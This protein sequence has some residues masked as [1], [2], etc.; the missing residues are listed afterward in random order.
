MVGPDERLGE[1]AAEPEI[2]GAS[3]EAAAQIARPLLVE[4]GRPD[5]VLYRVVS[6]RIA[7]LPVESRPGIVP[8]LLTDPSKSGVVVE[9][10]RLQGGELPEDA[11]ENDPEK[12]VALWSSKAAEL[13]PL[14]VPEG[15]DEQVMTLADEL[16]M[17]GGGPVVYAREEVGEMKPL[18]DTLLQVVG[19][20]NNANR[21]RLQSALAYAEAHGLEQP[22]V[23]TVDPSRI[24][25]EKERDVV[26]EFA[27]EATNELELFVDSAIDQGFEPVAEDNR[28]GVRF[29]PDG[30]SYLT[31]S[32]PDGAQMVV[33]APARHLKADG[34][35]QTGV[36]NAYHALLEHP[37]VVSED[38]QLPGS[39]VIHV[40][41]SH[42]GPMGA[43][44][45]LNAVHELRTS[46]DSFR[47]IGDNQPAR[48][49][50]AHLIE[51]GLT[52]SALDEAMAD[53]RL[54]A[55]FN[56]RSL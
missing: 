15:A 3:V 10:W 46:L 33:L 47:V 21:Q 2:C 42:Y 5:S 41:S 4:L 19:A 22:I 30:S 12:M 16:Q 27:P 1:L 34:T 25:R 17:R 13:P 50:Q 18:P 53:P 51:I 14:K 11:A 40:T 8:L 32:H 52:T 6:E 43:M 36:Y 56:P 55:A 26:R 44:N 9:R 28:Y 45:N 37:E 7:G 35:K 24:L 29:L 38:F 48:T 39:N 31:M 23:A 54:A 49:P 20:A